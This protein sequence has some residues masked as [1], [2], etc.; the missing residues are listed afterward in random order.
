MSY[1]GSYSRNNRK[2]SLG[3]IASVLCLIVIV[4]IVFIVFSRDNE[5]AQLEHMQVNTQPQSEQTDFYTVT[6]METVLSNTIV[7]VETEAQTIEQTIPQETDVHP[8]T[9][10]APV[11]SAIAPQITIVQEPV[12]QHDVDAYAPV[13][14]QYQEAI[15]MDSGE[16][17]N[18]YGFESELD[19]KLDI[20]SLKRMADEGELASISEILETPT[21]RDRLPYVAGTT[22]YSTKMFSD[23]ESFDT[24]VYQYA[25]YNIDGSRSHELLI[26]AY[27]DYRDAYSILAI[28]TLDGDE[29]A[30]LQAISDNARWHLTIY[31]D[32]TYCVDGSGGASI[33]YWDYYRIHETFDSN[34]QIDSFTVCYDTPRG[35]YMSEAVAGYEALLTPVSDI[36]WQPIMDE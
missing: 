31:E 25:Y 3:S 24:S 32:G 1:K 9:S 23:E 13:I 34:E 21:L 22:L 4:C 20:D 6:E 5:D 33:H 14:R 27:N 28:Y 35:K 19:L 17:I 10:S 30:L 26:G 11:E 29:P 8:T 7:P 18:L 15:L 36:F 16:F 12:S 2:R